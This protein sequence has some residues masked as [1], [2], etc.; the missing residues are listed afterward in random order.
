MLIKSQ[1]YKINFIDKEDSYVGFDYESSCCERFWW[2]VRDASNQVLDD[3]SIEDENI[4]LI[5]LADTEVGKEE[6]DEE[7]DYAS[8]L[9]S[10]GTYLCLH[11]SHNGYYGHGW[12][13]NIKG[14]VDKGV[15]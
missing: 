9:L 1:G 11:N 7:H 8:F 4:L 13:S 10:N 5:G 14:S 12:E 2:D 6:D 15:L 3:A